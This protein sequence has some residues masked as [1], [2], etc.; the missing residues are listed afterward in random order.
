M[1]ADKILEIAKPLGL[2][3]QPVDTETETIDKI[4]ADNA[5]LTKQM[6]ELTK[7]T[8]GRARSKSKER[9]NYRGRSRSESIKVMM[10][11]K[12]AIIIANLALKPISAAPLPANLKNQKGRKTRNTATISGSCRR[13][14]NM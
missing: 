7:Q 10:K 9:K 14:I 13:A 3:V 2:A 6:A 11:T 8:R 5:A 1:Q 12:S 4:T